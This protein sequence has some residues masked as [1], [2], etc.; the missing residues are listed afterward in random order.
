[1]YIGN[2]ILEIAK[3]EGGYLIEVKVPLKMNKKDKNN[4]SLEQDLQRHLFKETAKEL[5]ESLEYILPLVED[6]YKDSKEFDN[7]FLDWSCHHCVI[8]PLKTTVH[9]FI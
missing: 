7:A 2:K 5:S 4:F 9:C 3:V 8:S 1:M 6:D